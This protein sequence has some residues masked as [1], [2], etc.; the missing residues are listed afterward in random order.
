M[1]GYLIASVIV[2]LV[3]F[4]VG[5]WLSSGFLTSEVT[6][7]W[8]IVCSIAGAVGCLNLLDRRR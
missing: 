7:A 8:A 3:T 4:A 1:I 6:A 5:G 2:A